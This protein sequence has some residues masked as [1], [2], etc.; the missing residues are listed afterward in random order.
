MKQTPVELDLGYEPPL[1]L[2][3]MADLQPPQDNES[4]NTLKH[5]EFVES[6]QRMLGVARDELHDAQDHMMASAN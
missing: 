3:T 5:P 4:G 2:D 6:L 1:P